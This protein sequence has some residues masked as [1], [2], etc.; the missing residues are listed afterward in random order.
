MTVALWHQL[1]RG[2]I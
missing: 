1:S 2:E